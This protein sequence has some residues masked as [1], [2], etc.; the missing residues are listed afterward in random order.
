[1]T[2]AGPVAKGTPFDPDDIAEHY[3]RLH[4]QPRDD[5]AQEIVH[6]G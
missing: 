1:M 5:W 3:W 4:T 6:T 2:A